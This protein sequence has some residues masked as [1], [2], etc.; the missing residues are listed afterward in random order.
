[1]PLPEEMQTMEQH[2]EDPDATDKKPWEA[3]RLTELLI[4]QSR[5]GTKRFFAG[6]YTSPSLGY[7]YGPGS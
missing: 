1:M 4:G 6:E 5:Q 3:P 7:T 2:T